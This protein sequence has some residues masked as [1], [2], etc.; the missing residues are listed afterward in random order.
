MRTDFCMHGSPSSVDNDTESESNAENDVLDMPGSSCG[1]AT[2]VLHGHDQHESNSASVCPADIAQSPAFPP[3]QPVNVQF[4]KTVFG[5]RSRS[6]NPAWYGNYEWLEYSLRL[7]AC[8]CYPCRLFSSQCSQFSSCPEPA[9]TVNGF[10]NWKH[11][12]GTRGILNGHAN[13]KS[14]KQAII[15][16]QQY[17]VDA[18]HGS[19]ISECLG[20][21][22]DSEEQT[23]PEVIIGSSDVML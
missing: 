20:N 6:F 17:K 7:N 16:W 3:V 14:H 11:A 10:K 8:F 12:T 1:N 2:L 5:N 19:T 9:F 23:L 18:Q 13:C 22:K 4:P 15:A 21:A